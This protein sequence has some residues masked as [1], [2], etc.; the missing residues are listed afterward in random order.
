LRHLFEQPASPR[1]HDPTISVELAEVILRCLKKSPDQRFQ[2]M[3]EVAR[4]LARRS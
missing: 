2:T 4:A 1:L 3:N